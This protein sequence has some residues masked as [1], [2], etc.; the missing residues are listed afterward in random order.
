MLGVVW[1]GICEHEAEIAALA[2]AAAVDG[3]VDDALR[4]RSWLVC[5]GP[6]APAAADSVCA[7]LGLGHVGVAGAATAITVP[8]PPAPRAPVANGT[9]VV[10]ET[11][12][13]A[14]AS[15]ALIARSLIVA[16]P[17]DALSVKA[18]ATTWLHSF[19]HE[20]CDADAVR[21]LLKPLMHAHLEGAVAFVAG[22]SEAEGG[23]AARLVCRSAF[24][25]VRAA[26]GAQ[27]SSVALAQ[28][29][30]PVFTLLSTM[31]H[32]SDLS[33]SPDDLA[34]E[35]KRIF[36]YALAWGLG[37]AMAPQ[38]RNALNAW[39]TA[40]RSLF[41]GLPGAVDKKK[42]SKKVKKARGGVD[43]SSSPG[44]S[45]SN[46]PH[47][48]KGSAKPTGHVFHYCLDPDTIEWAPWVSPFHEMYGALAKMCGSK[49]KG[50]SSGVGGVKGKK[51]LREDASFVPPPPPAVRVPKCLPAPPHSWD[52]LVPT[53][54]TARP[55]CREAALAAAHPTAACRARR[56]SAAESS[57]ADARLAAR[58]SGVRQDVDGN[59]AL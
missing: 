46:S 3:E 34:T 7:A 26:P 53:L 36:V 11:A 57:A 55:V 17:R 6:I 59:A 31:L 35:L 12:S 23:T 10:F 13:L 48:H 40:Q 33:Q 44:A 18:L 37:S 22:E 5:D 19:E 15:P 39:I 20:R 41:L 52:L 24:D 25:A 1:R 50:S 45:S 42:K 16:M 30:A 8:Y 29:V 2:D 32:S 47:T 9:R 38:G 27:R 4:E 49:A 51:A 54:H 56:D 21:H 14:H 43:G 58:P 28:R